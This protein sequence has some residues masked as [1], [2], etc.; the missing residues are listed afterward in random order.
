MSSHEER[1]TKHAGRGVVASS[2]YELVMNRKKLGEDFI[3]MEKHGHQWAA[4]APTGDRS[5]TALQVGKKATPDGRVWHARKRGCM[6]KGQS[7]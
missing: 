7:H 2:K 1:R 3:R 4:E 5:G 6:R